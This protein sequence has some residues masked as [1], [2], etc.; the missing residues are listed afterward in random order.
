M[1]RLLLHVERRTYHVVIGSGDTNHEGLIDD[2]DVDRVE[3][4]AN[5]QLQCRQVRTK[6]GKRNETRGMKWNTKTNR[7]TKE[8]NKR[9]NAVKRLRSERRREVENNGST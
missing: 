9:P 7:Y 2:D 3:G 1:A 8:D 4:T 5:G 6:K